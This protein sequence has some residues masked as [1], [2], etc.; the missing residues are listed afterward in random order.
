MDLLLE[1]NYKTGLPTDGNLFY[2]E[3]LICQTIEL[4]WLN[5]S[6]SISCIPEG[7]YKL[8]RCF[9]KKFDWHL[10]IENVTNRRFITIHPANDALKELRGCIAPVTEIIRT[11][12]GLDSKHA[13]KKLLDLVGP[14]F[15]K[16]N[17]IYLTIKP[18][19]STLL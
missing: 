17:S 12:I 2:E 19:N 16:G 5:N 14:E 3:K 18:S 15:K 6:T 8:H 7:R 1:R 4:P 11:G 9:S 10:G 13:L